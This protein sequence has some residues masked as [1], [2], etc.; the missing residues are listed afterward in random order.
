M[1]IIFDAS[2]KPFS[3]NSDD[4]TAVAPEEER[5]TL[6]DVSKLKCW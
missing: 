5:Q 2:G 4:D 1:T 3:Q 6:L